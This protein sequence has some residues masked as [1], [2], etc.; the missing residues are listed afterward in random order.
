MAKKTSAA[1]VPARRPHLPGAG[2]RGRG[3]RS[4]PPDCPRLGL[5]QSGSARLAG[6]PAGAG[7]ALH[8]RF[9]SPPSGGLV[10]LADSP[11][12]DCSAEDKASEH[13]ALLGVQ[14]HRLRSQLHL[15]DAAGRLHP[16]AV[17]AGRG[18]P[19]LGK[20]RSGHCGGYLW[21]PGQS[22]PLNTAPTSSGATP[23]LGSDS[24]SGAS[25][26]TPMP[27]SGPSTSARTARRS[28]L[29]RWLTWSAPSRF[30]AEPQRLEPRMPACQ[31]PFICAT[32]IATAQPS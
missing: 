18:E 7:N 4:E 22:T 32:A 13:F 17:L 11:L 6:R 8:D 15:L 31:A 27:T 9:R 28:R 3:A 14:P 5:P 2:A 24:R 12:L 29:H 21:G 10:G 23:R 16:G 30:G 19:R 25:K 26:A 1:G 20:W